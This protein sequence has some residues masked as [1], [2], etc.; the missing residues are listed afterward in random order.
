[1]T[2]RKGPSNRR[3]PHTMY[4][5]SATAQIKFAKGIV[6]AAFTN[7]FSGEPRNRQERRGKEKRDQ[8]AGRRV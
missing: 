3:D 4:T 6:S 1:M 2:N 5:A 8:K 7:G